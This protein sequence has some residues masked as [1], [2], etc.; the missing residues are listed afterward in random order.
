MDLNTVAKL[1]WCRQT[2]GRTTPFHTGFASQYSQRCSSLI[3]YINTV[4]QELQSA[5]F[6]HIFTCWFNTT[7]TM[8]FTRFCHCRNAQCSTNM[9]NPG[10]MH[11]VIH[12]SIGEQVKMWQNLTHGS[13]LDRLKMAEKCSKNKCGIQAII[14]ICLIQSLFP[15]FFPNQYC[16]H[17]PCDKPFSYSICYMYHH[18]TFIN[19]GLF[20]QYLLNV[21]NLK[22]NENFK[23]SACAMFNTL[24][25]SLYMDL[26]M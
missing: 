18:V 1:C 20:R 9:I 16:R 5:R 21:R 10:K 19:R 23:K 6:C 8:H 12:I 4:S 26:E 7:N 17:D 25:F 24:Q 11:C 15:F 14:P 13:S 3:L 2:D 22:C